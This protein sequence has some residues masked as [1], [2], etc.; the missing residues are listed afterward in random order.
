MNQ[1][2]DSGATPIIGWVRVARSFSNVVSPPIIIAALGLALS[3]EEL[4]TWRGFLWAVVF[5]F[6]VSLIPSLFV[7]YMLRTGR[8]SDLHMNTRRERRW[9][10]VTG[11]LG[12]AIALALIMIFGGP[13]NLRC[14]AIFSLIEL[15]ILGFIT[16]FWMISIHATSITAAMAIVGFIFGLLPALILLPLVF[17]VYWV[18]LYLRRHNLAQVVAG[19]VLGLFTVFVLTLGGCFI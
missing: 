10:Y 17:A 8:I 4:P 3:L 19:I 12:S 9:P 13:E 7:L 16:N 15:S 14:L 11:V 2:K 18:R 1:A 5:G 6:W